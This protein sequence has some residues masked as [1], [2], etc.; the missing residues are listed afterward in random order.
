VGELAPQPDRPHAVGIRALVVEGTGTLV[1]ASDGKWFIVY[2]AY[3]TASTRSDPGRPYS[4]D[5]W[6]PTTG[7]APLAAI[8]ASDRQACRRRCPHGV[9]F[10]DDFTTNRMG[11]RWSFYKGSVSDRGRYRYE[12][13]WC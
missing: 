11:V 5:Q 7:S 1:E 13:H 2:H 12:R 4:S 3:E 6:T 9:A 8:G 10:S